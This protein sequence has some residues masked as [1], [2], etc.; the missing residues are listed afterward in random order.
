MSIKL[1]QYHQI[2]RVQSQIR[3]NPERIAFREWSKKKQYSL[4]WHQVGERLKQISCALLDATVAIQEPVT[5]FAN[6]SIAWAL[7]DLSILQIRAITVPIYA[8]STVRQAAFIINN[9]GS[10]ILFVGDQQQM[11]I[12]IKLRE[13]CPNLQHIIALSSEIDLHQCEIACTLNDFSQDLMSPK[14]LDELK[15]RIAQC[16][17]NDLFTLIYTSGTTGNPKGVMLDYANIATQIHLHEE[18]LGVNEHDVSLSFLPL[19]HVFERAW[20][21]YMMHRGAQIVYLCDTRE[22]REAL[23][24]VK[25]TVMCSVPRFYEKIYSAIQ[26][27]VANSSYFHRMIFHFAIWCG[28]QTLHAYQNEK[29]PSWLLKQF[30]QFADKTILSKLRNIL[31]GNIRFMPAAGAKLDDNIISFFLSIGVNIIYG[32]GMTETCAT[33]SCWQVGNYYQPG[34]IGTPLPGID[35]RIGDGNEIQ[36]RGPIVT[37][38]YYKDPEQTA[39]SFTHDG[40]LKTGDAGKIDEYGHVYI[41]ERIKELMK[42]STGKY[43]APQQIEG[44]IGHD[45]FIDQIAI[46]A[47]ARNFVTALIVPCYESL[48][49]YARL[50][51]LKY[52]DRLELLKNH[53]IVEMFEQRLKDLQ[54]ELAR[55]EQVKRFTLLPNAFSMEKGELTPTLKLRR[56]IILHNYRNEIDSMYSE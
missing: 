15:Q 34:S 48:E 13:H 50:I 12:A 10:R 21:F 38:G 49:E 23:Q 36:V 25:P 14:H 5:I 31:G 24:A 30:H 2:E 3:C 32:Y 29:K 43:I 17:L 20:S 33:V 18:R 47:D 28:Q 56:N 19:S 9:S 55:F 52:H 11:D 54:K 27:K 22:I 16:S 26:A 51:N 4:T 35:V 41:T 7:V 45:R 8:T 42:T 46:I 39:A 37:R 1:K 40:W 44:A 53:Q 6:N